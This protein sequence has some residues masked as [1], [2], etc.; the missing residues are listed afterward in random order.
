MSPQYKVRGGKNIALGRELGTGGEGT[1]Y[2]VQSASI[3]QKVVAK[4]YHRPLDSRA[5]QKLTIMKETSM[6]SLISIAAWPIDI[7][8]ESN[9]IVGFTMPRLEADC[10]PLIELYS[11]AQR[12]LNFA[13]V[14]YRFLV[15]T[16]MN[17]ARA[18][19][20][21]HEAGHLVGDVNQKNIVVNKRAEIRLVDCD[22]FQIQKGKAIFPC[23]VGVGEYTAPELTGKDFRTT[24][25]TANHDNFGLAV[26]IFQLLFM[27]RSPFA[28]VYTG[29]GSPPGPD[30]AKGLYMFAYADDAETR[31]KYKPP[32]KSV[33]FKTVPLDIRKLFSWSLSEPGQRGRPTAAQWANAL[34]LF[35]KSLLKCSVN[36]S[37]WYSRHSSNCS[38]CELERFNIVFFSENAKARVVK[39]TLLINESLIKA[40]ES[41]LAQSAPQ[42]AYAV[43]T[44]PGIVSSTLTLPEIEKSSRY[45][46]SIS[47]CWWIALLLAL[48]G[49]LGSSTW[50]VLSGLWLWGQVANA[51][52]PKLALQGAVS[53]EWTA[54]DNEYRAATKLLTGPAASHE[55]EKLAE[56]A[57]RLIRQYSILPTNMTRD[58]DRLKSD[59][60]RLQRREYL[61]RFPI[62]M[63]H[64]QGIGIGRK[65]ALRSFGIETAADIDENKVM[66]IPGFGDAYT[67]Y[68]RAWRDDLEKGFR[69]DPSKSVSPQDE[70]RVSNQYQQL[71]TSLES[72]L[73]QKLFEL[74]SGAH[75]VNQELQTYEERLRKLEARWELAHANLKALERA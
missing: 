68:L 51:D 24:T 59:Q 10:K 6:S 34:E 22:S 45:K 71:V 31:F 37:H 40:V 1:V 67:T 48:T 47:I 42:P 19:Q 13:E 62:E 50:W 41:L 75:R 29:S 58:I 8:E 64:A 53:A 28:G 11:P 14:D 70:A 52:N 55:Q 7:I 63:C 74:K 12:K 60:E 69:F 3:A 27:G 20:T 30:D 18:F 56:E 35:A 36:D 16:A 49:Q 61:R 26:L 17:L 32:P 9:R 39:Q 33:P 65:S 72:Q 73:Q 4:I 38:W 23:P 54:A 43:K 5:A 21:V 25:R 2:V 46:K 66:N 15:H 57:R 44:Q